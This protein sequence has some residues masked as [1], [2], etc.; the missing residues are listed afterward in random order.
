MRASA[1]SVRRCRSRLEDMFSQ[2]CCRARTQRASWSSQ[3]MRRLQRRP[4]VN[5]LVAQG[6]EAG[7]HVRGRVSTMALVPAVVDAVAPCR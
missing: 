1:S 7:G 3:T 4:R 6:W 2:R 5:V